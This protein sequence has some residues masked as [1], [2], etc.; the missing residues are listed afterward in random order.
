MPE[1]RIRVLSRNLL[2]TFACTLAELAAAYNSLLPQI[3]LWERYGNNPAF[4]GLT[5]PPASDPIYRNSPYSDSFV[6]LMILDG[7]LGIGASS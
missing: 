4:P 5:W 3:P 7:R 1:T 2:T 6:V